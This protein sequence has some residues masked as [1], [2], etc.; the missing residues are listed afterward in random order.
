MLKIDFWEQFRNHTIS[1]LNIR[2]YNN[3]KRLWLI[4]KY[5]D[6]IYKGFPNFE[7]IIWRTLYILTFLGYNCL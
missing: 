2:Q 1:K 4:T 6:R 3:F 5:R 7:T